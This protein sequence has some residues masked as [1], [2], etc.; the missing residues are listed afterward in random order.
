VDHRHPTTEN[1]DYSYNTDG[2]ETT[3]QYMPLRLRAINLKATNLAF[4]LP[5]IKKI[6]VAYPH[7]FDAIPDLVCPFN[8]DPTFNL[9]ADPDPD[10]ATLLLIEVLRICDQWSSDLPP[11]LYFEP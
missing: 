2:T 10:P 1:Q 3:C 7:H 6:R 9:N 11:G 4:M 8:A 5:N